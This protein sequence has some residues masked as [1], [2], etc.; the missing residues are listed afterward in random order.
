MEFGMPYIS[1]GHRSGFQIR[2]M[3]ASKW[4]FSVTSARHGQRRKHPPVSWGLQLGSDATVP[5]WIGQ[6]LINIAAAKT[7]LQNFISHVTIVL[8]RLS[9]IFDI[10]HSGVDRTRRAHPEIEYL[11]SSRENN[12]ERVKKSQARMHQS[13]I[14]QRN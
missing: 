5:V 9:I 6:I 3:L 2:A 13:G 10:G 4:C 11:S 14:A 8:G 12:M 7:S 1:G